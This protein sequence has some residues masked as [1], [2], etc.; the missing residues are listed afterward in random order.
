MFSAMADLGIHIWGGK[1]F[2]GPGAESGDGVSA[3]DV[4]PAEIEFSAFLALKYD[5]R[6][7][8]FR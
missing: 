1:L 2:R 3:A 6:W 8:Q 5:I 7:Q 4:A